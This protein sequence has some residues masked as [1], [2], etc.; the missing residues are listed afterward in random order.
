MDHSHL[1]SDAG[2]TRAPV[3]IA[4]VVLLLC[5]AITMVG[6]R[7]MCRMRIKELG[8]DD[9][10]AVIALMCIIGCGIAMISMTHYGLGRHEWTISEDRMVLY[11]RCFWISILFYMM[12][13]VFL[14]LAFLFQYYRLMSVSKMRYVFLA[15]IGIVVAWAISQAIMA[16]L[17]CVPLQGVWDHRINAKCIPRTVTLW[18]FNGVFNIV[19]DVAIL[20]LPLPI[21]WK[22]ELPRSQKILL[23]CIFGLGFL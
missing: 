2:Q 14:K 13:L 11:R 16:F 22:L 5:I 6:L 3:L 23:T 1:P 21:L 17:Q 19:T 4:V 7:I 9:L 12:S 8:L 20:V 15:A 10:S 18:Y